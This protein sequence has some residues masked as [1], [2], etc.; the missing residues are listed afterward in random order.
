MTFVR[1]KS[2]CAVTFHLFNVDMLAHL[3]DHLAT[4]QG[5]FKIFMVAIEMNCIL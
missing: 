3:H 1:I 4:I 2:L 5:D